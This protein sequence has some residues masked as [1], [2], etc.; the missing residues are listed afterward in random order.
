MLLSGLSG[1]HHPWDPVRGVSRAGKS[2]SN[3]PLMDESHSTFWT[4]LYKRN[5]L[6]RR[7]RRCCWAFSTPFFEL[8]ALFFVELCSASKGFAPAVFSRAIL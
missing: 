4:I 2:L 7:S 8:L 3:V 5:C 6:Y 1:R